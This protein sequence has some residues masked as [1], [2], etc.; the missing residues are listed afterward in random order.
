MGMKMTP[1]RTV[2]TVLE[3]ALIDQLYSPVE[4]LVERIMQQEFQ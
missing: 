4:M 2:E 1:R 3:R